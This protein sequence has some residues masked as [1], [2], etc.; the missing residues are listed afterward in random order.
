MKRIYSIL[1]AMTL[2][3]GMSMSA[4]AD[5]E[6]ERFTFGEDFVFNGVMIEKGTYKL[7][8]D[9]RTQEL[10]IRRLNNDVVAT[11]KVHVVMRP[12]E[13]RHTAVTFDTVNGQRTFKE[14][15]F[16]DERYAIVLNSL[17]AQVQ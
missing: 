4:L 13:A 16:D 5:R 7:T 6:T 9:D 10:M 15:I 11:A 3:I 12:E 1:F 8:F 17:E 2:V 14:V